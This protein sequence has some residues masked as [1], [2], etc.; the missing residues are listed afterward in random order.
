VEALGDFDSAVERLQI[1]LEA[2]PH[3]LILRSELGRAYALSGK[4]SEAE[5]VLRALEVFAEQRYVSAYFF[6]KIYAGLR[7]RGKLFSW[8]EQATEERSS[9]M[10]MLNVDPAFD[11]FRSDAQFEDLLQRARLPRRNTIQTRIH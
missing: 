4:R 1:G 11:S 3:N 8:L 5:N 2:E 10:V 6:A 9:W 7:D